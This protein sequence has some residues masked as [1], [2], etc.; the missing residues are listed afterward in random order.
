MKSKNYFTISEESESDVTSYEEQ[1]LLNY[2]DYLESAFE[3]KS[4]NSN[5]YN[6]NLGNPEENIEDN[7]D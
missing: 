1:L 6:F 3:S 7:F 5:H 2:D 4:T